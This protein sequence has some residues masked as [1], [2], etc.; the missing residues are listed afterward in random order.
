[1]LEP[2]SSANVKLKLTL[3]SSTLMLDTHTLLDTPDTPPHTPTATCG[4]DTTIKNQYFYCKI[5]PLT[6]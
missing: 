4:T 1:M 5:S 2:T 6:N 3:N